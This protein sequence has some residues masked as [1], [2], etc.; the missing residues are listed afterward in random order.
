ME[1]TETNDETRVELDVPQTGLPPT[2][3][4]NT[5]TIIKGVEISAELNQELK[6]SQVIHSPVRTF[7]PNN[8]LFIAGKD[9]KY[10][11]SWVKSFVR[12]HT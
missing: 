1:T 4:H 11:L 8:Q 10:T 5:A 12:P 3:G 9:T 6:T 7:R 2:T